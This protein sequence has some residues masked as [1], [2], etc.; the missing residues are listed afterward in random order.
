MQLF[1]KEWKEGMTQD[2]GI[3]LL[4]KALKKGLDDKEK[5]D[6]KRVEVAFIDRSREFRKIPNEKLKAFVAKA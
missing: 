5:M 6:Y 1:E 2:E 3:V 4:M